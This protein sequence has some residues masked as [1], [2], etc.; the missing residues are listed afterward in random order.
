M[1]RCKFPILTSGKG[2]KEKYT[3]LFTKLKKKAE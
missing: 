3:F 2:G 1:H